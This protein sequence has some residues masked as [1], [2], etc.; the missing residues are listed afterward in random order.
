MD[1]ET[2]GGAIQPG[3]LPGFP[4]RWILSRLQKTIGDVRRYL[5]M[6]H[7]NEATRSL[8]AFVWGEYCDWYLELAKPCLYN[9]NNPESQQLTRR[10]AWEVLETLL[11]LLHPFMPFI[12]EEIWQSLSGDQNGQSTVKSIL[13]EPYPKPRPE[14]LDETAEKEM[15]LV[16]AVIGAIRNIRGEMNVPQDIKAPVLIGG[17]REK[18]ALI[19]ASA[20][21]L[22]T[23]ANVSI[24]TVGE[25]LEK[26]AH[27]ATALVQN[28]EIFLPLEGIIDI[29][30]ERDR[31]QKELRRMEGFLKNL[32]SK[33][34][35]PGFNEKAPEEVVTREK[36][37]R[38]DF[39]EKIGK[40]RHTLALL[41]EA[42]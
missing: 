6:F 7:F 29:H 18:T 11:R 35:N 3:A 31:I 37:K 36:R 25:K 27:S 15:D 28:L 22:K 21:F 10:T 34:Q 9:G 30:L 4:E 38:D 33:L 5:E 20:I 14:W 19:E 42:S 39:Q 17:G 24:L 1:E 40:L 8:Y 41:D 16:Q 12:T 32:E 26:P 23:L 13:L 2:P